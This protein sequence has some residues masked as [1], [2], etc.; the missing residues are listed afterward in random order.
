MNEKK[1]AVEF[2][3]TDPRVTYTSLQHIHLVLVITILKGLRQF[4]RY[5]R[6]SL[7]PF[8]IVAY[9]FFQASRISCYYLHIIHHE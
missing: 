7:L 3:L 4:F 5:C 2:A 8:T 9:I 1:H 6:Y